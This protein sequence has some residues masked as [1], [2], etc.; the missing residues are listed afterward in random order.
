MAFLGFPGWWA[1]LYVW[2]WWHTYG[3]TKRCT[4]TFLKGQQVQI[5]LQHWGENPTNSKL[6]MTMLSYNSGDFVID[7][8][9]L[10]ACLAEAI[11]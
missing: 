3:A 9:P 4:P 5:R 10:P 8:N 6:I 1:E 7:L 2:D 11:S